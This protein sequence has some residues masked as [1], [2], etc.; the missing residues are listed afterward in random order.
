MLCLS[1]GNKGEKDGLESTGLVGGGERAK[2]GRGCKSRNVV[3]RD[4]GFC[5]ARRL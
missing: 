5:N 3:V 2:G 4:N 1:V